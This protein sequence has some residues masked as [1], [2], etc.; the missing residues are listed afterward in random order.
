MQPDRPDII[1]RRVKIDFD[2]SPTD[3]W[4]SR[5]PQ[6]EN[7]L[8]AVS[9][10]LPAGERFFIHSLQNVMS[11]VTD[12]KLR[13]QAHEFIYQE[14]MHSKEHGRANAVLKQAHGY[15]RIIERMTET[16]MAANR[17]LTPKS[18]QL[19]MTCAT[20]H[21][22]GIL[23]DVLL[24]HQEEFRA[25]S[26]PA[27]ATLWL[28][29]AVEET[30]H[31]AVCFDVY[32]HVYGKGFWRYLQRVGMMGGVTLVFVFLL[33]IGFALVP[34]KRGAAAGPK[35]RP[36]LWALTKTISGRMYL[37]YFRRSFHPWD[38]DNMA[39]V[40]EWKR[41]YADLGIRQAPSSEST[42]PAKAA[43]A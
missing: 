5:G 8:N 25:A 36:K 33:G 31:K 28:W 32:E 39:L 24:R 9:F 29:H 2:R 13:E 18:M 40:D 22:T 42:A 26:D 15:G 19:A 35:A 11:R 17:N 1:R 43:V 12:P 3:A 4:S 21:F 23:A 37:D 16:I 30:E 7:M 14:A 38:H 20:E 27:F 34:K 10:V 6:F 41:H